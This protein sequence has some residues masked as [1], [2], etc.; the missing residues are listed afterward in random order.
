[1][2]RNSIAAMILL[3]IAVLVFVPFGWSGQADGANVVVTYG[4][5]TYNNAEYKNIVDNYF[6][7]NNAKETVITAG[8]VNQ[9]SSGIS[10]RNYNSNQIFSCA[11][12]DLSSKNNIRIDVD[13]SKITL[14]T[15]S[16]YKSALDSAGISRGYVKITSPVAA[17]GESALAGVMK[18]YEESTGNVIPQEVKDAANNEI[19]T[20]TEIVENTGASADDVAKIMTEVKE[21]VASQNTTDRQTIINIVNNVVNNYN[22]NITENDINNIVDSVQKT[23]AVKDQAIQYENQIVNFVNS[24]EGQSIVDSIMN[25]INSLFGRVGSSGK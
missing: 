20:E 25:F 23:Q 17:T 14:V 1:M 5:T 6:S 15:P 13:S 21:Q 11:M 7:V 12:V 9:I 2:S 22:I 4:E 3:V 19:Y 16:M 18:S 10:N 24:S 8:D